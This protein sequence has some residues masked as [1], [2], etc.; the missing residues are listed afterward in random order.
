MARTKGL[1]K[2][3]KIWWTAIMLPD[4]TLKRESAGETSQRKAEE[5]LLK[6]RIKAQDSQEERPKKKYTFRELA[7][8]YQAWSEGRYPHQSRKDR[9]C[10]VRQL[11]ERFGDLPLEAFNIKLVEEFQSE[12]LQINKP[13]SVNRIL[14]VLKH[15]FTKAVDWKMVRSSVREGLGK[16]KQ[17]KE[18]PGR[19]RY[20][21]EDEYY[22]L[23]D[24]CAPHLKPIVILA[25]HTGMRMG[26]ILGLEWSMIDF[27]ND[28]IVLYKTKNGKRRDV[29]INETV[30]ATLE[31]LPH[32]PDSRFVFANRKGD[33]Y[34]SVNTSFPKAL[35][36]AGIAD[37]TFHDLRHTAG[38][39]MR[40]DGADLAD[41][42]EVLGHSR[43]EMTLRYSH[44]GPSHKKRAVQ[45][46]DK[47]LGRTR[48]EH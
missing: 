8:E 30:R 32:G 16:V 36:R 1:Y 13:A 26:E 33:P 31:E 20:L 2:R 40:M 12:R 44:L 48:V 28:N 42:R 43:M 46:L 19:T 14:A 34:K 4:G 23:L 22:R 5:V 11:V 47:R 9:N 25:V 39:W 29:P 18:P 41:I 27:Q 37:A 21:T 38:S 15:M 10:K 7:E 17:L 6:R 24:A 45:K 3:G 35:E